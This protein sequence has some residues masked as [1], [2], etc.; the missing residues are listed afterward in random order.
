MVVE[1]KVTNNPVQVGERGKN[2]IGGYRV[3]VRAVGV[4]EVY[5]G[6]SEVA[7]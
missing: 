6:D 2:T 3:V 5:R 4:E 7:V 1:V